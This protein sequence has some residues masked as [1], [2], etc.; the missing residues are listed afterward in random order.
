MISRRDL[1]KQMGAAGAVAMA[2][3]GALEGA[4][5]AQ[6]DA[7][8]ARQPFATLTAAEGDTLEAVVARIIPADASGPGAR[9]AGAAR[10]IDRA[11]GGPL[12]ASRAAYAAGLAALDAYARSAK[13][14]PF[15][16]LSATDQD[17]VLADVEANRIPGTGPGFFL[18]LRAHTI[19]GTF[20]DPYY[21]G[22]ANFAGWDLIGYPGVRVSVSPTEQQLNVVVP[23]NHKSAYDFGMFNKAK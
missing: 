2:P 8:Q 9:E 16:M 10:Y 5:A 3:A 4:A 12:A 18:L 14:A 19:D 20:S 22:N 6:R 23:P 13:G 7:A 11:L 21:G 1:L 17:A 15:A